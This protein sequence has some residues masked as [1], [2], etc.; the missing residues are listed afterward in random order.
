M[1]LQKH[2]RKLSKERHLPQNHINYLQNLK[3][4]GFEPKVIYD[5]GSCVLHWTNEAK[6]VWPNARYILFDAFEPAE[7]LYKEQNYDYFVGVL[8]DVDGKEIKFY[9]N[10]WFPGGNSYY[11]EIG[12]TSGDFFPINN[13]LV[14]TT[15]TL[16]TI[17]HENNFPLPDFIK[18][19]VQ[20]CEVDILNG[21]SDALSYAQRM[22]I[23]LQHTEYNEGALMVDKSLPYIESLGWICDAPLFQNNGCDGDYSFVKKV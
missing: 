20:G 18:I 4:S 16:N 22:I 7:F 2:L 10:D 9:Q 15:K 12:C 14:K 13:Y 3:K 8:S 1:D 5:I 19:D 17:I 23:E 11:R 6:K 21:A